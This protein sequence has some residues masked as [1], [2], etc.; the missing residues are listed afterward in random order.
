MHQS[1]RIGIIGDYD[2]NSRFHVATGAALQ[3]AAGALSVPV[4]VAWLPTPS[5]A[6]GGEEA[7]LQPFD[8]LWCAP[9][10]PYRSMEGALQ[11]IR[12][13]RKQGRPFIGT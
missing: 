11:A 7:I 8:A 1:L 2:P 5:L 3:H 4:D 9:G 6:G 12:F 10:S 13:A